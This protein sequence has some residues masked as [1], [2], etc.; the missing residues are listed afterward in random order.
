MRSWLVAALVLWIAGGALA[1]NRS[2][3]ACSS[4]F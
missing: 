4:C 1:G 2:W 3:R